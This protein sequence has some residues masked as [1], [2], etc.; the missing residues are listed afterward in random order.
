MMF[1]RQNPAPP[2][3]FSPME[4]KFPV[5]A[6]PLTGIKR[7]CNCQR[8]ADVCPLEKGLLP[9]LATK[10]QQASDSFAKL[11][12]IKLQERHQSAPYVG[13]ARGCPRRRSIG[14]LDRDWA[15]HVEEKFQLEKVSSYN[16]SG[17]ESLKRQATTRLFDGLPSLLVSSP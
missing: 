3:A 10:F 14:A 8:K 1:E 5:P 17:K 2:M 13:L 6:I 4:T 16:P 15:M 11:V 9:D 12:Y 7:S